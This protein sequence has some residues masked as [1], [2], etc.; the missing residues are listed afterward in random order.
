MCVFLWVKYPKNKIE[1]I[2]DNPMHFLCMGRKDTHYE[3]Y[4]LQ[5]NQSLPQKTHLRKQAA[6]APYLPALLYCGFG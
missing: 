3:D 1:N 5:D 2:S 4:K 6:K